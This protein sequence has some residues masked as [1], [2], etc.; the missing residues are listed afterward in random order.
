MLIGCHNE[1]MYGI[2]VEFSSELLQAYGHVVDYIFDMYF[3][4]LYQST[5]ELPMSEIHP[6]LSALN[7]MRGQNLDEHTVHL[8]LTFCF[9]KL[10]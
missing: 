7:A 6:A 5:V 2:Q 8:S 1:L 9:G 4:M 10:V 3:S